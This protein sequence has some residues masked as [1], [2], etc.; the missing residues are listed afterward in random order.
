MIVGR[1]SI[2][3]LSISLLVCLSVSPVWYLNDGLVVDVVGS[4]DD[5]IPGTKI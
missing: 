4:S 3:G 5:L 2:V 1:D